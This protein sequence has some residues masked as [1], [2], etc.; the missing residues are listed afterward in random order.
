MPR[1][2]CYLGRTVPSVQKSLTFFCICRFLFSFARFFVPI[3]LP[4]HRPGFFMLEMS[5]L[6]LISLSNAF[7]IFI[8]M[9]V[10]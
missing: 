2:E 3:F 1:I 6:M 9:I 4:G 8:F 7:S 5:V 10:G